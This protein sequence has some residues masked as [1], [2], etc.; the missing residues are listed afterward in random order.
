MRFMHILGTFR[1]KRP[2]TPAARTFHAYIT[3]PKPSGD[4]PQRPAFWE[5]TAATGR[6]AAREQLAAK[7][8]DA[9]LIGVLFDTEFD[10]TTARR[11]R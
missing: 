11:G 5:T 3:F 9:N 6:V 7:Y 1:G 10:G 4:Q 2:V 8:P